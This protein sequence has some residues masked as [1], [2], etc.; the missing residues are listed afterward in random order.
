MKRDAAGHFIFF[1][2][3]SDISSSNGSCWIKKNMPNRS[4]YS[5]QFILPF[6][7]CAFQHRY[8]FHCS[9]FTSISCSLHLSLEYFRSSFDLTWTFW[10]CMISLSEHKKK[11]F[12]NWIRNSVSF[13]H[14]RFFCLVSISF[15]APCLNAT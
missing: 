9:P 4:V 5:L 2:Y 13:M 14:Y 7:W 12:W 11:I 1:S 6:W 15:S 10:T 3:H 8:W